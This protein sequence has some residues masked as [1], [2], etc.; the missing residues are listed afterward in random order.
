MCA[1]E[2]ERIDKCNFFNTFGNK[3]SIWYIKFC[4]NIND[5]M[6]CIRKRKCIKLESFGFKT[7]LP[8]NLTPDDKK[9]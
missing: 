6:K 2:C 7:R 4:G 5:S 9:I 1:L 8:S 3:E